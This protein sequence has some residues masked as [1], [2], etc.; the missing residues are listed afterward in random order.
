MHWNLTRLAESLLSL[1]M[2]EEGGEEAGVAAAHEALA[3]FG[4]QYEAAMAAGLRRKLGL[5]TERE[6]DQQ[7]AEDLLQT[8]EK[9]HADMTLTF[10]LLCNAA[11]DQ[12]A[13]EKV[14]ALFR[15]PAAYDEWAARWRVR[16]T[17]ET[18]SSEERVAVMQRTNPAFIPRNHFVQAVIDAAIER[19]DF[20]PFEELLDVVSR[21]YD[22]RP[23]FE[24]YT[25]PATTKEC[26][27]QTFC[28]T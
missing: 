12:G 24:R 8:M 28:G 1:L 19:N 23:E 13:D 9:Q 22:D 7:L 15:D 14:R 17:E 11:V 10:R 5:L 26:V 16:M 2:E 21:P 25:V 6:G 20:Q 18:T 4:S 27:L 3:A